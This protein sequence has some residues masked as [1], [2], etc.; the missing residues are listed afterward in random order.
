MP[1]IRISIA[2]GMALA[3]QAP[4]ELADRHPGKRRTVPAVLRVLK[5]LL[6][7]L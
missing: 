6:W 4:G 2:M 5:T 7:P 1:R 3:G